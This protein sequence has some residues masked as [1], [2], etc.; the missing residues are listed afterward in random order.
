MQP[1]DRPQARR[2]AYR[3]TGT[4][5]FGMENELLKDPE[6]AAFAS[7]YL[8][9]KDLEKRNFIDWIVRELARDP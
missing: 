4:T 2:G 8:Q 6:V 1:S 9:I 7:A 5:P 3:T